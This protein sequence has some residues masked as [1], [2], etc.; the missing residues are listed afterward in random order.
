MS[1][2]LPEETNI[3]Y[4]AAQ[5]YS[6]IV[7]EVHIVFGRGYHV[8]RD[9]KW[10]CHWKNGKINGLILMKD[11]LTIERNV[12]DIGDIGTVDANVQHGTLQY[13]FLHDVFARHKIRIYKVVLLNIEKRRRSNSLLL[14]PALARA[15]TVTKTTVSLTVSSNCSLFTLLSSPCPTGFGYTDRDNI[16]GCL[17]R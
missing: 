17:L 5:L 3:E 7:G 14:E 13:P 12:C 2:V 6:V 11:P 8:G 16:T 9:R 4:L 10:E 15:R 1:F